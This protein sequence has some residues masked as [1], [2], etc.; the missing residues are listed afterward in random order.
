MP[1]LVGGM[2]DHDFYIPSNDSP[3]YSD[4]C[5][6]ISFEL[7]DLIHNCKFE[8]DMIFLRFVSPQAIQNFSSRYLIKCVEDIAPIEGALHFTVEDWVE[9]AA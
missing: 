9:S 5:D 2:L 8:S 6:R 1:R 4:T 3:I 7:A